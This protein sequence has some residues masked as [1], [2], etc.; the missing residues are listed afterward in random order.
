MAAAISSSDAVPFKRRQDGLTL[1]HK[2]PHCSRQRIDTA[3]IVEHGATN[4]MFGQRLEFQISSGIETVGGVNKTHDSRRHKVFK[5]DLRWAP[6]MNLRCNKP[7]LR[8][9]FDDGLFAF[10]PY[11]G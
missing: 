10:R 5:Q 2:S 3:Q 7:H 6:A 8:Q 1:P 11:S 9:A 4:T